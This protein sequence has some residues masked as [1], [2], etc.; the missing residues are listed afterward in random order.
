MEHFPSAMPQLLTYLGF[1]TVAWFGCFVIWA[2]GMSLLGFLE[3][4]V[5]KWKNAAV[6]MTFIL[7]PVGAFLVL[8]G[9]QT[10]PPRLFERTVG[11]DPETA[12]ERATEIDAKSKQLL[13]AFSKPETL[14]LQ[15]LR[16][17]VD[18]AREYAK[19][20]TEL[21]RLQA[22]QISE[23]RL[24]VEEE[25]KKAAEALRLAENIK[26]LTSEQLDAVKLLITKDASEQSK[27]SFIYGV[28]ASFPI[29]VIASVVASALWDKLGRKKQ[30]V[31][32]TI[33]RAVSRS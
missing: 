33:E 7:C 1:F 23:L 19:D 18:Q 6:F 8:A 15:Q 5:S 10:Y 21:N 14:T 22:A 3:P 17:L 11:S 27:Q 25:T 26:S 32:N 24:T 13:A 29:G 30:R 4:K 20:A 2:V 16:D 9:F 28:I 31:L 12:M